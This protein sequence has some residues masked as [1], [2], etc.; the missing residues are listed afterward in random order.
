MATYKEI[1]QMW[2][3]I[4]MDLDKHDIFLNTF[5]EVYRQIIDS[6]KGRPEKM[7]YFSRVVTSVHGVR[8][9]ELFEYKKNG[10]MV[11][12]TYCVYVPE[13]II[14]ALGGVCTGL[15]GGD[16]FWVSGGEEYLPSTT[17]PLIKSSMGSRMDRTSPFCQIADM[18]IGENTCDGKKKAW[19]ILS[20]DVPM[21]IMDIPQMKR[22][23][24]IQRFADEIR[25][26]IKVIQNLTGKHLTY[27][28]LAHSI[29]IIN[30]RRRALKRLNIA[31]QSSKVPISGRDALM[32]MQ[33]AFYDDPERF[34]EMTNL[35]CDELE[36]RIAENSAHVP[37][38]LPRILVTG[39]PMALPNWKLH[40]LI[41]TSGAIVVCEETC[42]GTRYFENLVD[43]NSRTLDEQIAAIAE[44]YMKT[45][46]ACFTPNHARIEDIL[47]YVKDYKS[48]G[49]I[50]YTLQFCGLYS[51]ESFLVRNALQ[52]E[53]I[54]YLHLETDYSTQDS[55]QLRTRIEAFMEMLRI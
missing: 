8:P 30:S 40:H 43:E 53:G 10:G 20:G 36:A 18:F 19:E 49:V 32:V 38:N 33:V 23:E 6:Q 11:F 27:E 46:C 3:D 7:S 17:C 34:T 28:S 51:T 5:P 48:D 54:P 31:R 35:L 4:G 16:Q 29:K 22:A 45:N 39:T 14:L 37:S 52:K 21:H 24:D 25:L 1:K 2:S 9:Y 44:R 55:G 12:G 50:D 41:E 26:L 13:E 47:R 42:T 15:C